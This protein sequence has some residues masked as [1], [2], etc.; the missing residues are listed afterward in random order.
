MVKRTLFKITIFQT[1]R[2]YILSGTEGKTSLKIKRIYSSY[3]EYKWCARA[4]QK[5]FGS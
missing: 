3:I 2:N 1:A 5:Y 4:N